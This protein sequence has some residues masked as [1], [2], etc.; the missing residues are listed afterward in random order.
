MPAISPLEIAG[1][2]SERENGDPVCRI[3]D[4]AGS[5]LL[6]LDQVA[7]HCGIEIA[8]PEGLRDWNL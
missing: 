4:G 7:R 2:T 5:I 3:Y 1:S 6:G 8:E